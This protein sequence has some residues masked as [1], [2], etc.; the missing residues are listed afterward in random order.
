MSTGSNFE[1][2]R[3]PL[4]QRRHFPCART[5]RR[6]SAVKHLRIFLRLIMAEATEQD[7]V[8]RNPARVCC[9]GVAAY[10]P[11]LDLRAR[12]VRA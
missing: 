6:G 4:P 7:Y 3:L 11:V 1:V 12:T 9:A 2:R 5:L 8:R 10:T